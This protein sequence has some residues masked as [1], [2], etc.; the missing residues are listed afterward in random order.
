VQLARDGAAL[1]GPFAGDAFVLFGEGRLPER[2]PFSLA[3]PS[4]LRVEGVA[5]GGHEVRDFRAWLGDQRFVAAERALVALSPGLPSVAGGPAD[6]AS[7]DEHFGAENAF[8]SGEGEAEARA[9]KA[10]SLSGEAARLYERAHALRASGRPDPGALAEL[11]R[12]AAAHPDE[13]L[14]R[15]ELDELSASLSPAA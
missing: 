5:Q 14:L 6:P 7:W 1:A 13:W 8:G 10:A 9:K 4:G 12:R 3:L 2:G 15:A 11:A